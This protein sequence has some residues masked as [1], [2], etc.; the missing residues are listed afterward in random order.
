M[1]QF[2]LIR[3]G[4]TEYDQQ[5][6]LQGTLNIPLCEDGR[7]DVEKLV[8]QLRGQKITAIY[9]SPTQSAEQTADVLGQA[10]DLKVKTIDKLENLDFGLWQGMLVADVKAKQPKVYRQWQEQPENVCPPQ[11]ETLSSAKQ[12][13]SEALAKLIKKQKADELFAVVAP[14]P[15]ASIIRN[16]IRQDAWEDLWQC[17]NGKP[18]WQL[19]EVPEAV[20][21][22]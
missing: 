7:Q 13:V 21:V 3:S 16:V 10:L 1:A 2:L 22:K 11:G 14:E 18:H 17:R 19:I 12:R 8:D 4:I 9:S 20:A 5:G 6:R 15:L